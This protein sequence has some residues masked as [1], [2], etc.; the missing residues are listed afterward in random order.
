MLCFKL[1][2]EGNIFVNRIMLAKRSARK[3]TRTVLL[4]G[5]SAVAPHLY[6]TNCLNDSKS[7]ERKR[8]LEASLEI[9]KKCDV[10]YVGQ[11]F[12]I[13]KGMAA[14]IKEAEKL[15]ILVFYRD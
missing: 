12:G 5:H 7:E 2:K 3:L 1:R 6:I 14:E 4:H 15:G 9:L 13:S 10:V 8:G 11:K